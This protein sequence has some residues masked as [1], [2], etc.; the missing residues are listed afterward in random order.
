MFS[1][2]L[3]EL[4]GI[5]DVEDDPRSPAAVVAHLKYEHAYYLKDEAARQQFEDR[6]AISVAAALD[7]LESE[8]R[9]QQSELSR[10][11]YDPRR[12]APLPQNLEAVRE[13]YVIKD[14]DGAGDDFP[15]YVRYHAACQRTFNAFASIGRAAP[16]SVLPADDDDDAPI[17]Y[18]S[19]PSPRAVPSFPAALALKHL[20]WDSAAKHTPRSYRP[21]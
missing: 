9:R 14:L 13:R 5:A 6:A 3:K 10:R 19:A 8:T 12:P 1:P 15:G 17:D 2:K 18:A 4:L 20:H 11:F 21:P 16:W 7:W